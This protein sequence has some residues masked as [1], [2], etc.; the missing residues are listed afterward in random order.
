LRNPFDAT[1]VFEFPAGTGKTEAR[2]AVAKR[3]LER[4]RDRGSQ[5]VGTKHAGSRRGARGAAD[6]NPG[7]PNLERTPR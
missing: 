7:A 6:E 2:E 3:L 1:E 5:A 4:A